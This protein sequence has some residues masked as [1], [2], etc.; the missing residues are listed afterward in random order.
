MTR[1][2]DR[3]IE[4]GEQMWQEREAYGHGGIVQT[5]RCVNFDCGGD[6]RRFL[7]KAM[8]LDGGVLQLDWHPPSLAE[9]N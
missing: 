5:L 2:T 6:R 8:A 3:W 1:R 4:A 9:S 7:V